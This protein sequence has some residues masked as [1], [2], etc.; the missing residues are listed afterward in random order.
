MGLFKLLPWQL[1][2]TIQERPPLRTMSL[3]QI[4]VLEQG[5]LQVVLMEL[6]KGSPRFHVLWSD[7][8]I[9][10]DLKTR[11]QT[12]IHGQKVHLLD[13]GYTSKMI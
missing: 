6:E 1:K 13:Q 3:S 4:N 5:Y 8:L 11:V 10:N 2:S 7:R 9:L 12:V